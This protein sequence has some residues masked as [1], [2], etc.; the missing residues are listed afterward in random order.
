[1][2]RVICSVYFKELR[3]SRPYRPIGTEGS[4]GFGTK[5]LLAAAPKGG[6][7]TVTVPNMEEDY[8]ASYEA[9]RTPIYEDTTGDKVASCLVDE[10]C[11]ATPFAAIGNIGVFICRDNDKIENGRVVEPATAPSERELREARASLSRYCD[12]VCLAAID[13]DRQGKRSE[14]QRGHIECAEYL[15]RK[16]GWMERGTDIN[17]MSKCPLCRTDIEVGCAVCPNCKNTINAKAFAEFQRGEREIAEGIAR[18]AAE[19]VAVNPD[20]AGS[21]ALEMATAGASVTPKFPGRK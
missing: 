3:A 11:G 9:R 19:A 21:E 6:Y 17:E 4:G 1:M 12:R 16:Y 13:L 15:G 14:I 8:K 7:A 2:Q 20:L 5:F 18:L 10:W